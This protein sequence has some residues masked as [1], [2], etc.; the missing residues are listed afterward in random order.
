MIYGAVDT[1][2]KFGMQSMDQALGNL[3]RQGLI[4]MDE[5]AKRCHNLATLEQLTGRK[6]G[7]AAQA[8]G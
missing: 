1:G 8:M 4:D 6:A 2:A 3:V 7:K 5:A